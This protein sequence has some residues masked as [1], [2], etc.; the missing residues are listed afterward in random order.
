M[1]K[2]PPALNIEVSKEVRKERIAK[3]TINSTDIKSVFLLIK[4]F[5]INL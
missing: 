2:P 1:I 3:K 5:K 4:G